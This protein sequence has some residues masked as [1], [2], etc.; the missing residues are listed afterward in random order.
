MAACA[1]SWLRTGSWPPRRGRKK[2]IVLANHRI[3]RNSPRRLTTYS[4]RMSAVQN[5]RSAVTPGECRSPGRDRSVRGH[6]RAEPLSVGNASGAGGFEIVHDE[7]GSQ[8]EERAVHVRIL[9]VRP[10][11]P[12]CL[13]GRQ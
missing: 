8:V 1:P 5:T 10:T 6:T 7:T 11:G 13:V 4:T 3:S 12:V 2:L 9:G